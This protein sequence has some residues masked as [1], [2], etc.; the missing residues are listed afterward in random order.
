VIQIFSE[1]EF[2]EIRIPEKLEAYDIF[3]VELKIDDEL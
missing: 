2:S 3:L 1:P